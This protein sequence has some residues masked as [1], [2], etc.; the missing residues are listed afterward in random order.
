FIFNDM[1]SVIASEPPPIVQTIPTLVPKVNANGNEIAGLQTLMDQLP[2]GTYLGWNIVTTGFNKGRIC[3]FTGG[4][5]PFAKTRAERIA[6]ND[7]RPS[8]EERYPSLAAFS[9]A[10]TSAVNK[11]VAERY[12][13]PD[14]GA[15]ELSQALADVVKNGIV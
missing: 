15:R 12:L 9:A 7:P 5:V 10:A 13:L 2:V 14:D 1:S 8:L 6:N 3:A 4:F 11:L